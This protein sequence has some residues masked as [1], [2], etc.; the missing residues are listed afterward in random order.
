MTHLASDWL[1]L[2]PAGGLRAFGANPPDAPA[3]AL[4]M[5]LTGERALARESWMQLANLNLSQVADLQASGWIQTLARPLQGPDAKL[6]DFLQH[7]IAALSAQRSAVLASQEGFCLGR[8]GVTQEQA[9]VLSAA[10]ADFSD[11]AKR[12]AKRGWMG[13]SGYV[14]FHSD[15]EFLLPDHAF[16]PFWVDGTGYWLILQGEPLLN[17]PAWVELLWG[18][19]LAGTRFGNN[20]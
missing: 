15:P 6:D 4:Q 9:D 5:L 7:V 19:K 16:I 11:Y 17:N 20:G 3:Q 13:A 2:T 14:A 12:Q 1:M 10:A 8:A 18:I